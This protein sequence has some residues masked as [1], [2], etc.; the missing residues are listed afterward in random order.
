MVVCLALK[1]KVTIGLIVIFYSLCYVG[2]KSALP[3]TPPLF[4]AA[5]RT[6]IGGLTLLP[7]LAFAGRGILP[8][9]SNWRWIAILAL[10]STGLGAAAMFF[11]AEMTTVGIA[12]VLGNISPLLTII[13]AIT[14]LHE[15]FTRSKAVVLLLGVAGIIFISLPSLR[16]SDGTGLKGPL[17]ALATSGLAA[18][19]NIVVKRLLERQE[20]L[21]MV[22]WQ[23]LL[24]GIILLF[25]SFA[26]ESWANIQLTPG[27]FVIVLLLGIFGTAFTNYAWY[28]LIQ[29]E[30]V[31]K[32]S[33]YFFLVPVLGLLSG[34][35][36]YR[37]SVTLA[38]S[39]G[40]ALI[41]LG[42]ILL[43]RLK[44]SNKERPFNHASVLQV[45]GVAGARSTI[46]AQSSNV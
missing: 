34:V 15:V 30:D 41:I 43:S 32:V 39:M 42:T 2:I 27:F 22:T 37:E 18:I 26:F 12:S 24:G 40:V 19:T 3:Y 20:L 1:Q 23:L 35:L 13:I 6:L 11:A 10:L 36:F 33:M 46:A 21:R 28:T 14:F 4:F 25:A 8:Q 7:M 38:Q 31:G 45:G 29:W 44:S 9:R 16:I 17:F 5:T